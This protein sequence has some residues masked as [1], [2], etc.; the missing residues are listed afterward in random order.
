MRSNGYEV[1]ELMELHPPLG[2][3]TRYS[4]MTYEWASRWPCEEVWRVRSGTGG[5]PA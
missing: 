4:H 3:A 2:A 5:T 1:L